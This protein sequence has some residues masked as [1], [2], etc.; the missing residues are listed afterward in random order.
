MLFNSFEFIFL[1][2][3]ITLIGFFTLGKNDMHR[4]AI[5]WLVLCS[6]F[7]YGWWNPIYLGLMIFSIV[8]NYT[9]G[10]KLGGDGK[11]VIRK[12]F[13]LFGIVSNLSLLAYFKYANFFMEQL[14]SV[15]MV[16]YKFEY[17]L[18]PLA[19]SFFTFQQIAFLVDSYRGETNEY[20]FLQYCLFVTFFPQLIAGPIVH[21][22]E[23]LPQFLLNDRFKVNLT[24]IVVG[25]SI[26]SIGFF[27][28][29]VIA[30]GIAPYSNL[31]FDSITPGEPVTFFI[32][33]GGA[34]AYTF[35][36][37]FDF[38]GYSDMAIGIARLFGIILPLNF[39][40]PY[41]AFNI[42]EFWR[43]WH[44]TLSN[45]LRDYVYIALGGNRNGWISRYKNLFLTMFLG[46]IWHGAGW[47]FAF[48]GAL[49]GFYLICNQ[50]WIKLGLLNGIPIPTFLKKITAWA[51]TF[52]AVVVGWVFFRAASFDD[53][54]I[55]I[56][57]MSGIHGV[58]IPNAIMARLD[59]F[60][61]FLTG[62]GIQSHLGGGSDFVL[63]WSWIILL[64]PACLFLP[65][66]QD[67]FSHHNGSLS[68]KSYENTNS[69]S[70]NIAVREGIHWR[71]SKLWVAIIS[72]A[73]VTSILTLSQVSEFLYFQF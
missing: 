66:T 40:S 38:S 5:A 60:Q 28:K 29:T 8:F 11:S 10:I 45:F 58:S 57:G 63:T 65:N 51:L 43:R 36:L 6:L 49:H 52:A 1:F 68:K 70:L 16:Q 73:L 47:N 15:L 67:L 32:A 7:F 62:L 46:G 22:K 26:F 4:P 25:L 69:I 2:L 19:I 41:K 34:L 17:V 48:W 64:L 50:S 35:Q 44:I 18:L 56:Q 9:L 12:Y 61:P 14:N 27:K 37:Y 13:L 30:D 3:P 71:K 42:S 33:W 23:M 54:L 31:V 24:N 20:N 55:I 39:Y 72:V 53:A 21:H 59:A